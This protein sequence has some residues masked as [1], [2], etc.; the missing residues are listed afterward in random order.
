MSATFV[1]DSVDKDLVSVNT[2]GLFDQDQFNNLLNN[3]REFAK[4]KIFPLYTNL[5]NQ[6]YIKK[7]QDGK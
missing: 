2:S 3:S 6:K 1:F 7:S 5:I 4:D